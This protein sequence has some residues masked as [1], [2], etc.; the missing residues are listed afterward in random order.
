MLR[1]TQAFVHL[2][3]IQDNV[4]T[5]SGKLSP[6]TRLMAVVKADGYGHGAA[7][8]AGAALEA[9]AE[10]LGVALAEEGVQLRKAGITAPI[11]IL[12]Q[13]WDEQIHLALSHDLDLTVFDL[14][15]VDRIEAE[16][17]RLGTRARIH[18]K[19]DTG[20]GRVG[21]PIREWN[22]AWI[23]RLEGSLHLQWMG[24]MTHFAESDNDDASYTAL[25][26]S[27][28]LD[29][30][31]QLRG[32][33]R[34]PPFLHAANSAAA[35][36]FPGTH[37]NLVRV[38]IAL[39]GADATM[40]LQPTLSVE[41]RI[42]YLKRVPA[43]FPVGYARTYHTPCAMQIASI[44]VGYADGYRRIFSN[45]SAV[46]IRGQRYPVVGRV[47]MDQITVGIPEEDS[48]A[49]GD[50][51]VLLGSDQDKHIT[52]FEWAEWGETIPY[53]MLCTIGV[54]VPRVICKSSH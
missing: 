21:I 16:A 37:F 31:E 42:V 41:S 20:M 13:S 5:I 11:L 34:L 10:W 17:K 4:K 24:L 26:L 35:L 50:R 22:D 38:G 49:V 33:H 46:L 7:V 52:I 23:Q 40:P 32:Q 54:R 15:T 18:L 51:V 30:I 3:H 19:L 9:G 6:G 14:G 2:D 27:R 48:V 53:E 47:S 8:V 12:G 36:R 44:P 29:I 43:H 28:F 1:P 45:R 39:Y 25:Q